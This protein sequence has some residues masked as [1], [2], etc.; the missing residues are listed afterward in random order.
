MHGL[1]KT[2]LQLIITEILKKKKRYSK[3]C[4]VISIIISILSIAIITAV[5]LILL[6]EPRRIVSGKS[7]TKY[8]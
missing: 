5:P 8:M 3:Q 7:K 6:I 4:I 2:V 1:I